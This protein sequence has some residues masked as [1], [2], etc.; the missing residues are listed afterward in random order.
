MPAFSGPTKS[1]VTGAYGPNLT[2]LPPAGATEHESAYTPAREV[3]MTSQPDG[4]AH[5]AYRTNVTL[6]DGTHVNSP[7]PGQG[8][9]K[10]ARW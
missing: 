7:M 3:M 9:Y 8:G 1:A 4:T 2:T 10:L 5:V 6:T